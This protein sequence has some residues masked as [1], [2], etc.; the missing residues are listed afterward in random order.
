MSIFKIPVLDHYEW[1]KAVNDKDIKDPPEAPA[2]GDRYIIGQ[3][4]TGLWYN[5]PKRIA[6]C[7]SV[8]PI[9]W[10]FTEPKQGMLTLVLDEGILYQY[11]DN[12]WRDFALVIGRRRVQSIS[13]DTTSVVS[14]ST[15]DCGKV[16]TAD[17]TSLM[18][19]NLPSVTASDIGV[20]FTFSRLN[21]LGTIMVHANDSDFIADSSAGGN[22]WNDSAEE[23]YTSITLTLLKYN[24]W[25]IT[26]GHGTWTVD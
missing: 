3:Y 18:Q 24:Q 6:E 19:F 5:K 13:G 1:Q 12:K 16:F 8:D 2:K 20:H 14:I 10:D 9:T 23:N 25:V 26:A 7:I 17:T 22:I 11:V 4:P 15:D 21:Q